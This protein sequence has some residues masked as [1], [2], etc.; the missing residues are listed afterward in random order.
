MANKKYLLLK[1][2]WHN[3][4]PTFTLEMYNIKLCT[5]TMREAIITVHVWIPNQ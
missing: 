5:E 1:I 3:F 4:G 2:K